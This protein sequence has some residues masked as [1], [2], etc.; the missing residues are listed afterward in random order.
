MQILQIE[1]LVRNAF[2]WYGPV[3]HRWRWFCFISP[4]F[5]TLACSVGFFRMTELR[6]DDPSYVF[7][8]SDARW[9]REISVFNENWPLDENKFL[10]GKSFEAKRFVNILIRA[11]DGGSI[12]RDNVLHEIEILNQW[13]MNNISIPTDDL[14]FNLT[15]QDLCLSYDWVCGANEHIQM[16]LRRNDV[17]QILDLHFPRGGT[18]DTPVYLGGIF[19]DVQFFQNGTL[20]DAKLTQLFYFLKQDQKMVEEYSSKFSYALETFL[21]QVYSSDVITLSF[22]H[23][24][25]LED[26]LD[27]NAKAFV[28]NFVVSFFVLAMYA[29]VSSFTLKSSSATKIDWISSKP[30]LAAAGMF[31]TV[32]SIISAFGFLFI[33]GVRYNVINTIIPFL[34]IAIGIDDMFLMNACWDQTSKS[35]SVPERMS[36]TLSHAGVAVTITN[37]TD[38]MSFAIGCITDLPGIQ[39]FCIYACV[40]VAFSYFYQ[41]TFFS[42]AMAIMGEVEREKR[43]C[44]FFYR[45]FQLVDISKMNEEADSK[46]QQIKSRSASPAPFNYL[47][48][49]NSSFSSDSDSFSSKKTIPAEFAWKEQQSPNSSLSKKSKDR[50]EKDRIVHFIGKIYGPFILS[51]SVR[52]FSGLIFVVYLAIAMYGCYNFREGLNPGN[53]VTN[54]HYI[55]K[56]FS[57]IKHFW[58]IG[59]QL[60]V[61]VLNPPNLTISENRNELLKVVSAFEN[62]QYT[63][64]REGTVFFL[65][66]YLNYLSELN[67][68]VEDTERLWKTKLNSWLKYTGGSTQWASNLKINKTD[69]SF[70]AFRFQ[71]A[72]KNFVEPNDHKHAAQLLRDIAD[73]QPFN[74]VVYHEAFP[75][76]DQYLI[77]LPATIQNV[78]ISLLCM[79]VVSFL[80]VPSL[81]S[82]FVIFVSI[83]SINIGVFGYMTLW[84]VNLDAV[85]M[86]S[87]IM[88]I[89]FA[90]DL[91]AHIIYAFVTS[92]GDTKQ[93]VIGA[94]E[95]L[96]WPIFQGASSTIAG[97]SI[98]YTVDA[99]IILVFFKTIWLTM[100]IGAIHGLFFIPIFLSLFPVEFF[101]IPKSS[102]LH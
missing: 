4:L 56:Y 64:G 63:L 97:I 42:G 68:E 73:H 91:S 52:I 5:L 2:E 12:M 19:G 80:L 76:A 33:L 40:S 58:R 101:R 8:P 74:V 102:E 3:V 81:P 36:K 29:L 53:L 7:T 96:G 46:L 77:I 17:N 37:V 24:Q 34:I 84:G 72:L 54:D 78:V 49:S 94:L 82:G 50:E 13:I 57:D 30:W 51:N 43:H 66:E 21:N 16:L 22:A 9:R 100:L 28:P 87:I 26:G 99:Y 71:I 47:S 25:S 32:L 45:T 14:K 44:L 65:L 15:Y 59:A 1:P 23:Y 75:F 41:L 38:V 62:T 31:S 79:A 98:L 48:S 86:I 60:H 85:S 83:V 10:P 70:Q 39:F 20:S 90:V 93:R 69:G 18:K 89:G 11:K 88:S 95:T 67:A 27:E 55:A 6:V 92:H 61:A 35:L